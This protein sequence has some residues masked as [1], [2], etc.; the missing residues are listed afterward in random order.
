M[1][2]VLIF[3]LLSGTVELPARI[4]GITASQSGSTVVNDSV[5]I[6]NVLKTVSSHVLSVTKN[7]R[8]PLVVK[9]GKK[10]RRF[11]VIKFPG[12]VTKNRNIYTA[13]VDCDE[14]DHKIPRILF[15]DVK[16]SKGVYRVVRIRMGPNHFRP[17]ETPH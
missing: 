8:R 3:A 12:E 17:G 7:R 5:V 6:A 15:A 14:F 2:L 16:I 13:Q 9:D 10:S 4:Q 11:I 1:R